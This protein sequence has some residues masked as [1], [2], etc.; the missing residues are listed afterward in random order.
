MAVYTLLSFAESA[1]G[2]IALAPG[3]ATLLSGPESL[4]MTHALRA[5]FDA[6]LVGV[7]TVLSDNPQLS[8]RLSELSPDIPA[9]QLS[10]ATRTVE[11]PQPLRVVLDPEL[12]CPPNARLLNAPSS[13]A[14]IFYH[15]ASQA[16]QEGRDRLQ[17]LAKAGAILLPLE[18]RPFSWP[19]ILASLE[20]KGVRSL[21]I[22]GG[23]AVISSVLESG[24]LDEIIITTAPI[25][26]PAQGLSWGSSGSRISDFVLHMRSS[27]GA[28][29]IS[30]LRPRSGP[31]KPPYGDES[32]LL[33]LASEGNTGLFLSDRKTV[34]AK[35][36]QFTAGGK[37][38]L[39]NIML[40]RQAGEVLVH[41]RLIGISAGSELLVY[42]GLA[43]RSPDRS[44]LRVDSGNYPF[45]Y[46]Y[47]NVGETE[48]GRRVFGFLAHQDQFYARP[49]ELISIEDLSWEDA[50]FLAPM[51]TAIAIAHD[52]NLRLGE[53]CLITGLGIIG[54][55]LA[56]ILLLQSVEVI[57]LEPKAGRRRALEALGVRTFDPYGE[58]QLNELLELWPHWDAAVN[59]SGSSL[60]LQFL[61][62]HSPPESTVFEAS[63][64][65]DQESR[66]SLGGAFHRK[67][68]RIAASQVSEI[69]RAIRGPW[70]KERRFE[71]AKDM[72][73]KI[74]PSK[75]VSQRFLLSEAQAAYDLLSRDEDGLQLQIVLE[76]QA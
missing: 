63:W 34:Q 59:L 17:A 28:D 70:D 40:R 31:R 62:D 27:L 60:A 61:I 21:F 35:Q 71:L 55:L 66:I 68:I 19:K 51:E 46:G 3:Q 1:N 2:K 44:L 50:I 26:L 15:A 42:Q 57:G 25:L 33:A 36:L 75:Y 58:E 64:Y 11:D 29:Q 7:G 49:S 53:R 56:E 13:S 30:F 54:L 37:V 48:S 74:R 39:S 20:E 76:P 23:Q 72:I 67:K 47:M 10:E 24:V 45:A 9:E 5:C 69:P 18:E 22:E 41:S 12:R 65:G 16:G 6:I 32:A 52:L 73:R 8:C 38:K 4:R 43:R 14:L